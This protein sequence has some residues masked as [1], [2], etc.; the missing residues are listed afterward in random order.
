MLHYKQA[1]TF[2]GEFKEIKSNAVSIV[3]PSWLGSLSS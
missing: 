1:I 2:S 3:C